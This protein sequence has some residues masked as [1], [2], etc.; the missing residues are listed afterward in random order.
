MPLVLRHWQY[1]A[2]D[3]RLSRLP[4]PPGLIDG[5]ESTPNQHQRGITK[6]KEFD[7]IKAEVIETEKRNGI[8]KL[9]DALKKQKEGKEKKAE[10]HR[11]RLTREA[12]MKY[13]EQI[14]VKESLEVLS[15]LV[16]LQS[17]H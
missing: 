7:K 16:Q 15:D 12:E 2:F 5:P 6:N 11:G 8:I 10:K 13:L 3:S 14:Q 17:T 4:G 9:A 1:W